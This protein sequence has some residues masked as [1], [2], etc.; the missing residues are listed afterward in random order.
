MQRRRIRRRRRWCALAIAG[1][2]GFAACGGGGGGS[3]YQEP[4]GPAQKT[5]SIQGGNFFFR[6]DRITLPAGVDEIKATSQQGVHTLVIEGV[7]GF[8]LKMNGSGKSDA[9]KVKLKPGSYTFFCDVP[10]HREAGME[11]KLVVR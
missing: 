10:G 2:F 6:P 3:S 9:L 11:G 5:V 8:K 4:K 1:A 7:K